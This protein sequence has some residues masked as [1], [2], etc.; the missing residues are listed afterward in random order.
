M[1]VPGLLFSFET[2]CLLIQQVFWETSVSC[3]VQTAFVNKRRMCC[4]IGVSDVFQ[5]DMEMFIVIIAGVLPTAFGAGQAQVL[6]WQGCSVPMLFLVSTVQ[7][8]W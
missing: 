8:S 6:C 5:K 1:A 4:Y 7:C 3:S 2:K